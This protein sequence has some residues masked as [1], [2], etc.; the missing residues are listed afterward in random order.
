MNIFEYYLSIINKVILNSKDVL[1][2][3]NV[4]NLKNANLEVPPEHLNFDLS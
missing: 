4:K 1:N 2:L 3:E